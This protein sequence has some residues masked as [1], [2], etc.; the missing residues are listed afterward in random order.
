MSRFSIY[1]SIIIVEAI[2]IVL[3][4]IYSVHDAIFNDKHNKHVWLTYNENMRNYFA[5]FV[6]EIGPD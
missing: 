5:I 4:K 1:F 2:D 6:I 3:E